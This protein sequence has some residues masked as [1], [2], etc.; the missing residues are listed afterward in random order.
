MFREMRR[1]K[2]QLTQDEC[3]EILQKQKRG[4]LS[5]SGDN[6]YPYGLPINYIY[7]REN[8]TICFHGSKEGHKIDAIKYCDKAS[9]CVYDDG[10]RNDGEWF[11]NFKS[12]IVFG[13]IKI[14]DDRERTLD[15]C[16][17]LMH[18][19]ID[20]NDYIANEIKKHGNNVQCMELIIENMTGKRIKEK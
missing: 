5:L 20:D 7:F 12:V 8:G 16:R 18:K 3:A 13:R 9:F 17:K 14:I 2:Q 10:Y 11:L 1:V 4:V 6:G 15:I 19:F